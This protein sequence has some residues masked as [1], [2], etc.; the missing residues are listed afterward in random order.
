MQDATLDLLGSL[1]IAVKQDIGNVAKWQMIRADARSWVALGCPNITD[2]SYTTRS[3][4]D[5]VKAAIEQELSPMNAWRKIVYCAQIW[6]I[7]GCPE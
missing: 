3:L 5:G 1:E 4:F 7:D 6:R 2:V